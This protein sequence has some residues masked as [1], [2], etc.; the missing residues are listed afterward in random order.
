VL[1]YA[2]RGSCSSHTR[3]LTFTI[4]STA[5]LSRPKMPLK[6]ARVA[7]LVAFSAR[8]DRIGSMARRNCRD[9][10]TFACG[11]RSPSFR[12]RAVVSEAVPYSR[13]S[14]VPPWGQ[15]DVEA[16]PS[17][18]GQFESFI[19][20]KI[21]AGAGRSFRASG[22]F[23]IGDGSPSV[24]GAQATL[25]SYQPSSFS[26]LWRAFSRVQLTHETA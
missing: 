12:R 11:A 8:P 25:R 23:F 10:R 22:I 5:T 15:P 18:G 20:M 6:P 2:I 19:A 1:E 16:N 4:E 21:K 17:A 26:P 3:T 7:R 9:V 14:R 13:R 24:G